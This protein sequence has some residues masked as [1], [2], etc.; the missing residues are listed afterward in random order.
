[1]QIP[2]FVQQSLRPLSEFLLRPAFKWRDWQTASYYVF[3]GL[4]F[5]S[6]LNF[7][8]LNPFA[9]LIGKP[10]NAILRVLLL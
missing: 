1:M 7:S 2:V 3:L 5:L 9:L 4:I 6:F 10:T 8:G